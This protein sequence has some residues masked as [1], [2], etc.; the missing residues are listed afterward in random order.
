MDGTDEMKSSIEKVQLKKTY[1]LCFFS[2]TDFTDKE[3]F[4]LSKVIINGIV[5]H[6]FELY[7][8]LILYGGL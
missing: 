5:K 2:G 3:N 7:F 4:K 1:P 6:L 8:H